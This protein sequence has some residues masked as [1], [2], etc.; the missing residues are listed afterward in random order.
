MTCTNTVQY[1]HTY[2]KL[3]LKNWISWK[4]KC[5]KWTTFCFVLFKVT[6]AFLLVSP[7]TTLQRWN[8]SLFCIE[9]IAKNPRWGQ[10]GNLLPF[11]P[12]TLVNFQSMSCIFRKIFFSLTGLL[13]SLAANTQFNVLLFK[14]RIKVAKLLSRLRLSCYPRLSKKMFKKHKTIPELVSGFWQR[15]KIQHTNCSRPI[16]LLNFTQMIQS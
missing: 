15:W 13:R 7:H 11:L 14:K 4:F 8:R 6:C 10:L 3:A 1:G 5:M 9:E 16:N 12:R 2:T